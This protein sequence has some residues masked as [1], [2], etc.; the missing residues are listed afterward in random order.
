MA[1]GTVRSPE[2]GTRTP[3]GACSLPPLTTSR[4]G[5]QALHFNPKLGIPSFENLPKVDWSWVQVES[6]E[7]VIIVVRKWVLDVTQYS[8]QHPGGTPAVRSV[9]PRG[10]AGRRIGRVARG[11]VGRAVAVAVAVAAPPCLLWLRH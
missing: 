6:Q 2:D 7:K 9:V 11:E 10:R 4:L 1:S 5:Q 3:I 8:S